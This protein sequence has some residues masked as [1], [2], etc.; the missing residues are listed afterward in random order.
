MKPSCFRGWFLAKHLGD[1][2]ICIRQNYGRGFNSVSILW[3]NNL[4]GQYYKSILNYKIGYVVREDISLEES[5]LLCIS[6]KY[7][8]RTRLVSSKFIP[9]DL[10]NL[11]SVLLL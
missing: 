10:K 4:D 2:L 11:I 3:W 8:I 1:N 7:L 6:E 9:K 5:A